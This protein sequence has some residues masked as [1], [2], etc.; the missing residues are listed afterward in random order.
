MAAKHHKKRRV[1]AKGHSGKRKNPTRRR[2]VARRNSHRRRGSRNPM[3]SSLLKKGA[4]VFIGFSAAKKVPPMLGASMNSSPMMSLLST[5]I[6]A[7]VVAWVAKRFIPGPVAEGVLWGGVG[8]VINQAWNS[9]APASIQGYA[10]VG[11][12]VRGGFPLPQGPVRFPMVAAPAVTPTGSQVN[13]GAFGS[14]W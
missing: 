5:A 11:D 6:T 10:G 2:S 9:W 14:A 7:G 8:G 1:S 4:G 3:D 12:F 13:V